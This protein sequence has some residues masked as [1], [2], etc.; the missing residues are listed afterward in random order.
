MRD[1]N[2][3]A[4]ERALYSFSREIIFGDDAHFQ[5]NAANEHKITWYSF[6]RLVRNGFSQRLQDDIQPV[7]WKPVVRT[8]QNEATFLV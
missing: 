2:I 6:N 8:L 5:S 7:S 3:R 4:L 1:T